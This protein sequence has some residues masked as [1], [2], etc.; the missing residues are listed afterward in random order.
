MCLFTLMCTCR[1]FLWQ[2]LPQPDSYPVVVVLHFLTLNKFFFAD[3]VSLL[4]CIS[5]F[6][7]PFCERCLSYSTIIFPPCCKFIGIFVPL[8]PNPFYIQI[9]KVL[10]SGLPDISNSNSQ[11]MGLGLFLSFSLVKIKSAH[12]DLDQTSMLQAVTLKC[13]D[14]YRN[15]I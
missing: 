6:L 5:S 1:V 3:R 9:P 14:I 15:C 12:G 10:L 7:T 8:R 2:D 11:I 4:V 13:L